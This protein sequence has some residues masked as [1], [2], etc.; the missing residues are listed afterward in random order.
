MYLYSDG[1]DRESLEQYSSSI[2][3]C[4][5]TMNGFGPDDDMVGWADCRN[6][7]RACY[8]PLY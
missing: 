1:A 6:T 5:K 7:S 3:W 2:C 4:H 8:T